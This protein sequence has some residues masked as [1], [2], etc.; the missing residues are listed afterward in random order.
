MFFIIF[1]FWQSVGPHLQV[2]PDPQ[3]AGLYTITSFK[4]P[5]DSLTYNTTDMKFFI[6]NPYHMWTLDI[7]GPQFV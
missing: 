4:E 1:I 6:G 7:R 5:D 3:L 2:K